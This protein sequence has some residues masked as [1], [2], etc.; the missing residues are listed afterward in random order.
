MFR[1]CL[2][3]SAVTVSHAAQ[4]HHRSMY[5][6]DEFGDYDDYDRLKGSVTV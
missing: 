3:C 5:D 6:D 4:E 2:T 1:D